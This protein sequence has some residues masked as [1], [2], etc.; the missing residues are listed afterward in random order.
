MNRKISKLGILFC[1]LILIISNASIFSQSKIKKGFKFGIEFKNYLSEKTGSFDK[2]FGYTFSG[3]TAINIYAFSDGAILLKTELNFVNIKYHNAGLK[4]YGI[5]TFGVNWNGLYYTVFDEKFSF[6]F[7]EFGLIPSYHLNGDDKIS[8]DFFIGPSIGIGSKSIET[9][10]LD[11]NS[12][13]YDPYDEYTWG[14]VLPTSINLGVSFYYK[15]IIFDLRYRYTSMNS[16]A[17]RNDF[18]NAYLQFGIAL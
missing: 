4:Y 16:S 13:R 2:S 6:G 5:D 3:F 8:F 7:L 11:K 10:H 17:R 9:K 14:F 1:V 15:P 12:L 18:T